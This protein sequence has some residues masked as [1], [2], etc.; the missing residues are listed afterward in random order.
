MERVR[1]NEIWYTHPTTPKEFT[2]GNLEDVF[3]LWQDDLEKDPTERNYLK[4]LY[5]IA[6]A[7]WPEGG[8]PADKES[9]MKIWLALKDIIGHLW[10]YSKE[11]PKQLVI[12]NV[13]I[14]VEQSIRPFAI[15]PNIRVR[16][17]TE[18]TKYVEQ[19]LSLA[20]ALYLQPAYDGVSEFNY[21]SAMILREKIKAMPAW[22][23]YG[24]GFF[25]VRRASKS[26]TS[27]LQGL[28]QI[29]T[30]Q[31]RKLKSMLLNWQTPEGL[32]GTMTYLW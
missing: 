1:L 18:R 10:A 21:K 27:F 25:I 22:E 7:P 8:K 12:D 28:R 32:Q 15:G 29:L 11:V 26:G 19:S 23:V 30:S 14:D 6:G 17:S 20:L 16:Q 9:E 31:R 2:L 24:A 3:T 4:F 13:T 5:I